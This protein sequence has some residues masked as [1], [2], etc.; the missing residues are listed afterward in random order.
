MTGLQKV[1]IKNNLTQ[2]DLAKRAQMNLRS[3]QYYEQ[4]RKDL[5]HVRLDKL[6][7]LCIILNCNISEIVEDPQCKFLY[8]QYENKKR[9]D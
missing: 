3:L 7:R 6:L 1:R 2:A 4:G 5:A 9:V 8:A